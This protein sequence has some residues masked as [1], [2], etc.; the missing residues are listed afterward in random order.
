MWKT[1][2]CGG[3]LEGLCAVVVVLEEGEGPEATA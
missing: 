3:E 2:H 1:G